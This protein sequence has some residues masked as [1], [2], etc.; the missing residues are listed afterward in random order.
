MTHIIYKHTAPDGRIYI[1]MTKQGLEGRAKGGYGY[2]STPQF[3]DAIQNFGWGTFTH[4]VLETGLDRISAKKAE[5]KYISLFESNK[6]DKGFNVD[7]GGSSNIRPLSPETRRK[8]S[9]SHKGIPLSKDHKGKISAALKGRR[10]TPQ[11]QAAS[12]KETSKQII[13]KETEKVFPSITSAAKEMGISR[14]GIGN[15]LTGRSKTAG[16]FHWRYANW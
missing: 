7:A 3:F 1:G 12:V 13:C 6:P 11:C 4:E 9:E 2:R 5:R 10:V 8:M 15:C 14:S 16:G